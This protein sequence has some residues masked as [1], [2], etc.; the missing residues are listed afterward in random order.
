[1]VA[2]RDAE[3][4]LRWLCELSVHPLQLLVVLLRGKRKGD[5]IEQVCG[6][7]CVGIKRDDVQQRVLL[8]SGDEVEGVPEAGLRP[9]RLAALRIVEL[10]L[11]LVH[12]DGDALI[13]MITH[14][15]VDR[16]GEE[17]RGI[18][19]LKLRLPAQR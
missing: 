19:L 8:A 7:R 5:W 13:V 2:H 4:R 12:S 10:G 9:A 18:H 6:T 16:A 15:G 14:D 11:Y 17:R 1:M 3:G